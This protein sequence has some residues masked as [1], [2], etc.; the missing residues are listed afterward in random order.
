M[1]RAN[2]MFPIWQG[3]HAYEISSLASD[4]VVNTLTN[5]KFD[6]GT[7]YVG[8]AGN[9]EIVTSGGTQVT[10]VGVLAGTFIPVTV[11]TIKSTGSGTTATNLV[12]IC[13]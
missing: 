9:L 12:V 10:L 4:V 11:S 5:S 8:G 7:L 6:T 13:A 3:T 1:G 2:G